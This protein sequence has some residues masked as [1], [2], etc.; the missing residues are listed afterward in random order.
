MIK[1]KQ[2]AYCPNLGYIWRYDPPFESF[3][4]ILTEIDRSQK[5]IISA[6]ELAKARSRADAGDS[7]NSSGSLVAE[8]IWN[9][10]RAPHHLVKDFTAVFYSSMMNGNATSDKS[11]IMYH[12]KQIAEGSRIR[13][14]FPL[15]AAKLE[16]DSLAEFLFQDEARPYGDFL[17]SQ[18]IRSVL[19]TFLPAPLAMPY[20]LPIW[21]GGISEEIRLDYIGYDKFASIRAVA[22]SG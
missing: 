20:Y 7:I 15:Q 21:I 18:G 6:R 4:E 12:P 5:R 11:I 14:H 8:G 17:R 10:C 16:K 1:A 3:E 2:E 13:S 22:R 9:H 19:V